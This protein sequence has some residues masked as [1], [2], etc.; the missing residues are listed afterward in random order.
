L[1]SNDLYPKMLLL[2]S[3]AQLA[4]GGERIGKE[5][6][7]PIERIERGAPA[8]MIAMEL[9]PEEP[10]DPRL[11]ELFE[12]MKR[13]SKLRGVIMDLRNLALWPD[14]LI[15]ARKRL[16]PIVIGPEYKQAV[17]RLIDT[18]RK[19]ARH[20]PY[21]LALPR[22]KVK[23]VVQDVEEIVALTS[24]FVQAYARCLLNMALL[25]CDWKDPDLLASSPFPAPSRPIFA[26][27]G[28]VR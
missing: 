22:E 23:A 25:E 19:E 13:T 3:A 14:Y 26:A 9:A 15:E 24:R 16:K 18:A 17:E 12:E 11:R 7:R 21:P 10:Q 1:D 4:L 28:G 5:E 27:A 20:L 8:G 6:T 2:T